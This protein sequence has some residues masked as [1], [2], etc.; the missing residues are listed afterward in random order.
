MAYR[1][2]I[3]GNEDKYGEAIVVGSIVTITD[4]VQ[5]VMTATVYEDTDL[6]INNLY[7]DWPS[8]PTAYTMD[9]F[10]NMLTV[11]NPANLRGQIGRINP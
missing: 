9:G 11:T 5:G 8:E 2:Y 6:D 7:I 3:R 1:T 10:A 4:P